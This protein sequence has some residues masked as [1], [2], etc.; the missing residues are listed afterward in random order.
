MLKAHVAQYPA[1]K[2]FSHDQNP[3]QSLLLRRRTLIPAPERED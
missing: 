2:T 1:L 3:E